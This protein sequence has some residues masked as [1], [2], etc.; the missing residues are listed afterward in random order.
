MGQEVKVALLLRWRRYQKEKIE[1]PFVTYAWSAVRGAV[2]STYRDK[3]PETVNTVS[4]VYADPVQLYEIMDQQHVNSFNYHMTF[5]DN[6]LDLAQAAKGLALW[7]RNL[8]TL[9]YFEDMN[10]KEIGQLAGVTES[11][12]CQIHGHVLDKVRRLMEVA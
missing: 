5:I 8:L 9:R 7:E 6:T 3:R 12:V 4:V 1:I 11:R 2:V 10:L